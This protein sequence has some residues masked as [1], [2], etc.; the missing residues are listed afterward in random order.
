MLSNTARLINIDVDMNSALNEAIKLFYSGKVFI[1]PTDTIYGFGCNPFDNNA[2]ERLKILKGR[3]EE[4]KF[5]LLIDSIETLLKYTITIDSRKIN[6][7]EALWPNPVSVVLKLKDEKAKDLNS[8]N[9]AFRIPDHSFC[10][11]L[12]KG[13]KKPLISTSVN[14][15]N[16]APLND[17]LTIKDKFADKVSAVFYS[18]KKLNA[19]PSTLVDLTGSEPVV[20]REGKINFIDFAKKFY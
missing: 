8:D 18:Q 16:E 7:L 1:Y 14:L 4:K 3:Q 9:A 5:I 19:E 15:S 11:N 17:Y 2:L 13:I 20:L 12:L 10:L 6:L